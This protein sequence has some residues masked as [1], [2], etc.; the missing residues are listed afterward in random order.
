MTDQLSTTKL[1]GWLPPTKGSFLNRELY[2]VVLF[3]LFTGLVV[4]LG[5]FV[6]HEVRWFALGVTA[7]V[8]FALGRSFSTWW[9]VSRAPSETR[10]QAILIDYRAED[11]IRRY[12]ELMKQTINAVQRLV[13]MP[14]TEFVRASQF[15]FGTQTTYMETT[16]K[17]YA[18]A[19]DSLSYHSGVHYSSSA[20]LIEKRQR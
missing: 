4:I 5:D 17:S 14:H 18:L 19:I 13:P 3:T 7:L 15:L 6:P 11:E 2:F 16:L 8:T 1:G 12:G 20:F 9:E 10:K